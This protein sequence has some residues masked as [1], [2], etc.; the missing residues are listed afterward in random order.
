[1]EEITIYMEKGTTAERLGVVIG[2]ELY[3][4]ILPALELYA[5]ERGAIITE[6]VK[7]YPL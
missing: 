7:F 5:Q 6:T 3:H 2:E 1:M 4:N